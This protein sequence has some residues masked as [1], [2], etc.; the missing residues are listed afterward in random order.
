MKKINGFENVQERTSFKRLEPN[1]YVVKILNAEDVPDKEYL[2]ISFDITEGENKGYF[3]NQ[4]NN[5]TRQDKKW[6]IAGSF[7]RS[8]KETA[9]PMF[10]GFTNALEKSNNGYTWDWNEKGL[11]NK[12]LVVVIGDEEYVNQ[13]GGVSIRNYVQS[14]RSVEAYK[15]GDFTI[16]A[17]KKLANTA[18]TSQSG[19]FVD[20]F[21]GGGQT[22]VTTQSAQNVD[23]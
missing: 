21:G 16:P 5:D 10:K 13:K 12:T 7:I 14:V 19:D 17:L 4:F 6:P 22:A 8:Y 20:P 11:K 15:G 18:T 3:M 9:L 23:P 1:A 2:R